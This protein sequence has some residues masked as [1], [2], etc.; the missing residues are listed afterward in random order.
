MGKSKHCC[1]SCVVCPAPIQSIVTNTVNRSFP[2]PTTT[3]LTSTTESTFTTPANC[4]EL[5]VRLVGGGSGGSSSGAAGSVDIRNHSSSASSTTFGP[6]TAAGGVG[7]N[8]G[9]QVSNTVAPTTGVTVVTNTQ[10]NPGANLLVFFA[11]ELVN[12]QNGGASVLGGAGQGGVLPIEEN[13]Y[14][15]DA[16]ANSG[17][18]GGGGAGAFAAGDSAGFGGNAGGFIEAIITNPDPTYTYQVGT[19]TAGGASSDPQY[20]GGQG[21]DGVIIVDAYV[22]VS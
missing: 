20:G 14:G 5:R 17:S 18:G 16:S 21:A 11:G 2:P 9:R 6:L 1:K 3:V 15:G 8:S 12:G 10:G 22:G 4:T 7:T 13:K 19:G